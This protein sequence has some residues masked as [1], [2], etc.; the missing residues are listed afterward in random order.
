MPK[1]LGISDRKRFEE[2]VQKGAYFLGLPQ[3]PFFGRTIAC[4]DIT[5]PTVKR[6]NPTQLGGRKLF[7]G[8]AT[9]I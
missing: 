4:S 5:P 1:N 8:E 7:F 2:R 9:C 6:I 3:G